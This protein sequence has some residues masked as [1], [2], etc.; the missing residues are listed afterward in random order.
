MFFA[1]DKGRSKLPLI[2]LKNDR[3]PARQVKKEVAVAA[4]VVAVAVVD[5]VLDRPEVEEEI[6]PKSA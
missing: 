1:S 6:G 4:A 3:L 2:E 5:E